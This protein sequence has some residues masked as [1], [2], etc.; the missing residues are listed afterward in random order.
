[1]LAACGGGGSG[2]PVDT[3]VPT[4]A[5]ASYAPA[6][7]RAPFK[8]TFTF[9]APVTIPSA[10]GILAWATSSGMASADRST[11]TKVSA[12]QCSVA[13][14]PN[15]AKKGDWT[16][17]VPAGAYLNAAGNASNATA[18][19]VTQN[20]DTMPFFGLFSSTWPAGQI[21][22]DA[23]TTVTLRFSDVLDADLTL[24]KLAV[25]STDL[26]TKLPNVPGSVGNL[27]KTSAP[28]AAPVYTFVYTPV[29]GK[30]AVTVTLPAGS[31]FSGGLPNADSAWGPVLF[32][33][34]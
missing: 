26:T 10:D 25:S 31:V 7:A 17:T 6:T 24:D 20:I 27:V 11:F 33:V 1:M 32:Y 30:S 15:P 16:L 18:V 4:L 28:G 14:T 3:S 8:L 13:V 29:S 23:P 12:T 5:I 9:S 34:R 22:L 19:A 21:A 2:D